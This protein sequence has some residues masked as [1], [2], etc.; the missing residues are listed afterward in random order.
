MTERI[1]DL[2]KTSNGKYIAPQEIETRL[3]TDKYIEQ[4]AVIGDERNYVTAIISPSIPA[5]EAYAKKN[6]INYD[7]P[8]DLLKSPEIYVF[9]QNRIA[10]LQKDMANYEQIKK[11]TFIRKNFSIET[12]ELT[13]TLKIRR[14]V[15]LQKYKS[16]ID[17]MYSNTLKN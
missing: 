12:G 8:D 6:K 16:Q 1:K 5:L 14:S 3:G 7:N 9:L 10:E 4:L 13:N 15:I 17:E 2:F 11:F